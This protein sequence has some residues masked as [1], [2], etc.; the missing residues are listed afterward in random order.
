MLP[1][2]C[3]VQS[4]ATLD[5]R[6]NRGSLR[7]RWTH[8][9]SKSASGPL[10]DAALHLLIGNETTF[11]N[12]FFCFPNRRKKGDFLRYI[13]IICVLGEPLNSLEHLFL[14][15]HGV[16]LVATAQVGKSGAPVA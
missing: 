5:R 3:R 2:F 15:A 9:Q 11:L 14:N 13:P 1:Y 4:A 6:L 16:K 7:C 8:A 12:V 10:A